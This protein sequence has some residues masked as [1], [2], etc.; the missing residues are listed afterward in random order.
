MFD[1]AAQIYLEA[2]EYSN[3]EI[4]IVEEIKKFSEGGDAHS[5]GSQPD[6][7]YALMTLKAARCMDPLNDD[8]LFYFD[9]A[10]EKYSKSTT[11]GIKG[12]VDFELAIVHFGRK[13]YEKSIKLFESAKENWLEENPVL[14]QQYQIDLNIEGVKRHIANKKEKG[15]KN[16]S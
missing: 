9:E 8:T 14:I 12:I 15:K 2:R 6:E 13:E 1:K 7:F 5:F 10:K 3:I 11:P 4:D 16:P